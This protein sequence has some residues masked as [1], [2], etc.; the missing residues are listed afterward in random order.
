M[1]ARQNR[2][3]DDVCVFLNGRLDDLFRRLM[4]PR[5][6]HLEAG[7]AKRPRNDFRTPV[8]TV[9]TRLCDYN[10]YRPAHVRKYMGVQ[11]TVIGSSPAWPNPGS[12]HSGYVVEAGGRL[13]LDCGP[14]VLSRLRTNG[15]LAVDAIAITHFH[16]DHWGDLVPWVWFTKHGGL[17]HK[18]VLWLPP[19]GRHELDTFAGWWGHPGMFEETFEIADYEPHVPFEAAG[20]RLVAEPMRHYDIEA[21]GFRVE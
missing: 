9:E 1:R 13:L 4:K 14:G 19:T 12:A 2:D 11:L 17:S 6:D 15:L 20:F 16:L 10:A 3:T 5:V 21:F 8:M 7:I 18:P